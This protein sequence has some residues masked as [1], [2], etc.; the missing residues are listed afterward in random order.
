MLLLLA[1]SYLV[2][3]TH[4]CRLRS[5]FHKKNHICM[6]QSQMPVTCDRKTQLTAVCLHL[7]MESNRRFA[8]SSDTSSDNSVSPMAPGLPVYHD[9]KVDHQRIRYPH[10]I[11]WTPIPCLTCVNREIAL[12]GGYG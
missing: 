7:L 6:C 3:Q 4:L 10:C 8:D 12:W 2:K 11:V 5:Q 9:D 1:V